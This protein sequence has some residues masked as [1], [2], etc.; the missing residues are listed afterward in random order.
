MTEI[1][2]TAAVADALDALLLLRTENG[3]ITAA[4]VADQVLT[5]DLDENEAEALNQE[6]A[7]HDIAPE[8]EDEDEFEL[9][10]SIG[11]SLYTTDSFQ[12]FLNEAGRY[13]LL[14]AAEEVELAKRIERGDME[15]KERM[16]NCNLRLVVS[17]AKRYQT[18]GI[19]LGDL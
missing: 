19:T 8:P 1:N 17:I 6:L 10:L 7:V 18:Q 11:T 9:D 14:T 3:A 4:D 2:L 16:I 12:M 5:H 13:P 15:A